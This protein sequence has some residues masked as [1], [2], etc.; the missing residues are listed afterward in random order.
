MAKLGRANGQTLVELALVLPC[1]CLGIFMAV[2]LICS[3]H[4]MLELERMATVAI[5]RISIENYQDAY[6]Y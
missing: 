3:C 1:F 2:Q 4:N 5:N 6:K